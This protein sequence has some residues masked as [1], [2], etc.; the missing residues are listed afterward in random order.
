MPLTPSPENLS[1]AAQLLERGDVVAMPTETVYGLA[2]RIDRED[3]LK[4][5][6]AVKERPFFDPLIVHVDGVKMARTCAREWP[7]TADALTAAF[8]PGPLTIVLPKS[9]LVSDLITSGLDGVGLRSPDH[10]IARQLIQLAQVPL[11]APSANRFGHTSPSTW[12]HV[13]DEFGEAVYILKADSGRV[14]IEST[15][16]KVDGDELTLLRP[17][18]VSRGQIDAALAQAGVKARWREAAVRGEAPGQMKHHYMP[19]IPLVLVPAEMSESEILA[20]VNARRDEIP[21]QLEGVDLHLERPTGAYHEL[22]ELRLP[23]DAELAARRLYA[24]LRALAESGAE[25]LYFRC[26]DGQAGEHWAAVLERL[27]KAASLSLL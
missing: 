12:Q 18:M 3:G 14:G 7:P 13:Q 5:I 16:L 26:K 25:L 27:T 9:E 19:R 1:A 21:R 20:R 23:D 24:D 8:W 6:F 2:A 4:R 17:G 22:R 11:A 15:V 10:P